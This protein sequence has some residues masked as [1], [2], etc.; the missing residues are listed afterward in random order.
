MAAVPE[1]VTFQGFLE[2]NF[3]AVLNVNNKLK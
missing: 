2:L 3:C 1:A